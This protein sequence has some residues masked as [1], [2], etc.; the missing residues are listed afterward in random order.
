VLSWVALAEVVWDQSRLLNAR[1]G[2]HPLSPAT[3]RNMGASGGSCQ[4]ALF[5][6][7]WLDCPPETFVVQPRPSTTSVALPATDA[8]HRL[9]WNLLNLY[10]ALNTARNERAETWQQLAER[11]HCTTSQLTG[12]RTAKFATGMRL[13][14]RIAQMLRRPVADFIEPASW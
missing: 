7:R 5:V 8:A 4:H 1:L 12:L 3:L 13:A 14:M 6:L 10:T 2:D 11:L 9:R